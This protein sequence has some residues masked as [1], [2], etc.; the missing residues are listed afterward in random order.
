MMVCRGGK[1]R[2]RLLFRSYMI[3]EDL[4]LDM[5]FM[6]L[7]FLYKLERMSAMELKTLARPVSTF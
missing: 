2:E 7:G 5:N 3:V 4:R 6:I 1:E